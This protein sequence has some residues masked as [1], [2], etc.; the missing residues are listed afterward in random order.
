M[1]RW[2]GTT[3]KVVKTARV[4]TKASWSLGPNG[5][6]TAGLS[7]EGQSLYHPI[8]NQILVEF[9]GPGPNRPVEVFSLLV[10]T[11]HRDLGGMVRFDRRAG[12]HDQLVGLDY[13]RG[14]V[15]GGSY[16][17]LNGRPN[18]IAESVD[19]R[20]NTLEAFIVD[21]WRVSDRWTAVLGAQVVS[22]FRDILTTNAS[23]GTVSHPTIAG[24]PS[25]RA[26]D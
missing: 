11:D 4:A 18:G 20:A 6:L 25:T 24:P 12:R 21:R 16:R 3:A 8:V 23:T 26:P 13:G 5:S 14:T 9:D 10:D 2:T 22:A 7:Y 19:N 1:P 15:E 17:N